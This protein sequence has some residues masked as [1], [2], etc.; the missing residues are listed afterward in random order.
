MTKLFDWCD[1]LSRPSTWP[2]WARRT[3]LLT[4]PISFPLLLVIISISVLVAFGLMLV[5]GL[6]VALFDVWRGHKNG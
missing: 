1:T 4:L 5:V 6:M 3:Y 2:R